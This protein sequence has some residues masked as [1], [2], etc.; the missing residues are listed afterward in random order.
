MLADIKALNIDIAIMEGFPEDWAE[1]KFAEWYEADDEISF[2]DYLY[3]VEA[4]RT[5]SQWTR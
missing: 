1:S 4:S 5:S 3:R 2:V